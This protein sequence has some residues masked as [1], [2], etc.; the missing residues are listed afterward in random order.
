MQAWSFKWLLETS[1]FA[2]VDTEFLVRMQFLEI[3]KE[4]V[5]DLLTSGG[6]KQLEVKE[7]KDRVACGLAT[8]SRE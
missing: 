8:C 5:Y 1:H 7:S 2:G 3:Y 6:R 4:Q